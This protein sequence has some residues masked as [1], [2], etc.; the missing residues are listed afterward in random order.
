M[1]MLLANLCL[2]VLTTQ[3]LGRGKRPLGGLAV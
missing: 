3:A 1:R 2:A